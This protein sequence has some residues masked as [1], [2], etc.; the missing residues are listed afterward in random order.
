MI[1]TLISPGVHLAPTMHA[2]G[3]LRKI[4][5]FLVHRIRLRRAARAPQS[6]LSAT[7]W[8]P[9]PRAV[10]WDKLLP[11]P[12][13]STVLATCIAGGA[14]M[15]ALR[16][17]DDPPRHKRGDGLPHQ[18]LEFEQDLESTRHVSNETPG[19]LERVQKVARD[20]GGA[21][22]LDRKRSDCAG[23]QLKALGVSWFWIQAA[24]LAKPKVTVNVNPKY[25]VWY[26]KIDAGKVFGISEH[27]ILDGRVMI[28]NKKGFKVRERSFVEEDGECVVTYIDYLS[29]DEK[30]E[31]RRYVERDNEGKPATYVVKNI[32]TLPNGNS[33]CR[34]SCFRRA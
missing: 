21:W 32:L 2:A 27:M 3:L 24:K 17:L 13:D 31:I 12:H 30:T 9:P 33:I 14:M 23:P 20:F 15:L 8:T 4:P 11:M 6:R 18:V 26:E 1:R 5:P 22:V 29:R 28:K 10:N 25:H 34:N 19:N 7:S 16:S